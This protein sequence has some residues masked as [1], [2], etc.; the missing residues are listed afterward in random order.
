MIQPCLP[1]CLRFPR[2]SKTF[3]HPLSFYSHT[4]TR[5]SP[6]SS[7]CWTRIIQALALSYVYCMWLGRLSNHKAQHSR[8]YVNPSAR[9]PMAH[10][11]PY[12]NRSL[13][14]TSAT[15]FFIQ[16]KLP[17]SAYSIAIASSPSAHTARPF[18]LFQK[19]FALRRICSITPWLR[20]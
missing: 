7:E 4:E 16:C 19:H 6:A 8:L 17:R 15:L 13:S 11:M 10:V 14:F 18:A 2:R 20:R 3:H 5:I 12:K 1:T 9:Y